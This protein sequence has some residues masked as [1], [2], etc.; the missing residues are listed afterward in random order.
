VTGDDW[1]Q[2]RRDDEEGKFFRRVANQG[3]RKD[4]GTKQSV[5]CLTADGKFLSCRPG[6]VTPEYMRATLKQGLDAWKKLPEAERK[7]GAVKVPD[8]AKVD[9]RFSPKPP[10]GGLILNVYA[11]ILDK[12][13]HG[14]IVKG[15]CKTIGGDQAS[16]DHLWITAAEWQALVPS[17][18]KKGDQSPL[19]SRIAERIL[20]FH[21]VDNTRGEPPMWARDQVRSRT[22]TLTVVEATADRVRLRLDGAAVLAT[23]ADVARADRGFDARLLGYIDYD[24]RKK[25]ITRFDLIA[26]GDSWGEGRF[27]G[28][29]RAGRAPLGI[30][31][32]LAAGKLPADRVPPQGIRDRFE[33]LPRE[34]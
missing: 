7:P 16:R 17:N 23:D 34:R 22:L 3:P 28:G 20:R 13:A 33:Y 31:F 10:A 1:Y 8:L 11:R 5:Y 27:T 2:R 6:D 29:A 30:A 9:G 24:R 12:D 19:P 4:S 18:P 21:L 32:D 25:T 14:Q 26:V 15:T